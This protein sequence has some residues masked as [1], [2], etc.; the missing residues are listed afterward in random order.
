[1]NFLY[2]LTLLASALF[3]TVGT[4][5]A[6]TNQCYRSSAQDANSWSYN[7]GTVNLAGVDNQTG[8]IINKAATFSMVGS[9]SLWCDCTSSATKYFST[10]MNLPA[11]GD[12]W[13]SIGE[14]LD[15]QLVVNANGK[16]Y[17]MPFQDLTT[18]DR[19]NYCQTQKVIGG[20][21][22]GGSGYINFKIRKTFIGTVFIPEQIIAQECITN[23]VAGVPCT[24][25]NA[26]YTYRFSGTIVAPQTCNIQPGSVFEINLGQIAQRDFVEGGTG[27]RPK[28]FISRPLT[29]KVNCSG[30]IQ[31]D[32]LLNMRLEGNVASGMPQALASDNSDV[33]VVITKADGS[34]VLTP[35]DV[36]SVI[37]MAL[38]AGQANTTIQAY[39]VSLTGNAPDVG[40][41]TT[42]AYLRFDFN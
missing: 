17:L 5:N 21:P 24:L 10:S 34:T 12:G 14:Y 13:Y 42:L 29:V 19:S 2:L 6:A 7:F 9:A 8:K 28:G 3:F 35:N 25:S 15:T 1:M 33:G 20:T 37:P 39:P 16:G 36:N 41:F 32:A 18:G 4:A 30:G 26:A 22:T 38:N 27:N 23:G 40:V 11:D 31:A